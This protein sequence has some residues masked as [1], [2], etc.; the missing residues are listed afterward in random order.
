MKVSASN[1]A[2]IVVANARMMANCSEKLDIWFPSC[3]K[4]IYEEFRL[5]ISA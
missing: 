3:F 1:I 4:A 2:S 5:N